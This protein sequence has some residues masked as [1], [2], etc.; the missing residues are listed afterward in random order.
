MSR[1]DGW[2]SWALAVFVLGALAVTALGASV[3]LNAQQL[4]TLLLGVVGVS[5]GVMFLLN[6]PGWSRRGRG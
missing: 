1:S 4:G 6:A 3:A 5:V 2:A